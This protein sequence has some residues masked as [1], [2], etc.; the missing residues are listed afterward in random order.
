MT[1]LSTCGQIVIGGFPGTTLPPSFALA[2]RE[3]RRGGVILFKPNVEGGPAT[4]AS[5]AREVHAAA[6]ET[7]FVGIDQEGGRVARLGPPL[8][9]VPPMRTVAAWKDVE[10]AERIARAGRCGARLSRDHDRLRAR[11]RREH[12]PAEP[13][14]SA[15]GLRSRS[16]RGPARRSA[17]RG[18][19]GSSRV[20]PAPP[21]A[22]T[23]R[24]TAIRRRTRT[25]ICLSS[26]SA[27]RTARARRAR[28]FRARPRWRGLPR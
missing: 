3:R 27:A 19:E 15:I 10:L 5:L 16:T 22:S 6:P 11:A 26:T 7:P 14:S 12:V 13:P 23:S 9:E 21:A 8:L 2:L 18:F 1:L 20:G 25:S 24:V 28:T 17:P 4:V